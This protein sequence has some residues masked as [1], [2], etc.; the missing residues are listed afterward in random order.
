MPKTKIKKNSTKKEEI[1]P[2]A[3][4]AE[5]FK[6]LRAFADNYFCEK[7]QFIVDLPHNRNCF[8]YGMALNALHNADKMQTIRDVVATHIKQKKLF[9]EDLSF[10][11]KINVSSQ[12]EVYKSIEKYL[13]AVKTNKEADTQEIRIIQKILKR[14][15][16]IYLVEFDK[17]EPHVIKA[18][19]NVYNDE[20]TTDLPTTYLVRMEGHYNLLTTVALYD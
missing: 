2:I 15:I 1:R 10:L 6:K 17:D 16:I 4:P 8:Y 3:D 11:I 18:A 12:K 20:T 5:R 14:K 7:N 19:L 13:E 9:L